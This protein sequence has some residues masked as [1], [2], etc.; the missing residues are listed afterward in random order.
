MR[1]ETQRPIVYETKPAT[2]WL[3]GGPVQ[4]VSPRY[5]HA[6]MQRLVAQYLGE[7]AKG[8][9]RVGTE[10]RVWV[11]PGREGARY[12]VPDIAF[13]SYERLPRAA[14]AVAEEPYVTPNAVFEIRSKDDRN[15]LVEHKVDVYLRAGCDLVAILDPYERRLVAHDSEAVTILAAGDVFTHA[16]LPEF[17]LPLPELFAELDA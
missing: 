9:G 6:L 15:I 16:A 12:L 11:S 5:A 7:W 4:K 17:K 3:L 14:R 2:E 10:W 13:V 8:R 1:A